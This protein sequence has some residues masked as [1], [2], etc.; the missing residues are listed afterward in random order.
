MYDV[1]IVEEEAAEDEEEI[2]L[3]NSLQLPQTDA[4]LSFTILIGFVMM[5][6]LLK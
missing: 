3:L 2:L 5:F 6:L 4:S 1:R